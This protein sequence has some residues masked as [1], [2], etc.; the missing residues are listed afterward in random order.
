MVKEL[1]AAR[2]ASASDG[3]AVDDG[4][5]SRHE[6]VART[7]WVAA[8]LVTGAVVLEA[9]TSTVS[10]SVTVPPPT[11]G[12]ETFTTSTP[13]RTAPHSSS[14]P[15]PAGSSSKPHPPSVTATTSRPA[16][17]KA[18]AVTVLAAMTE[19]ERV[20]QL[21]MVDCPSTQASAVTLA[22]IRYQHVGSVI[23]DG[24]SE[25]SVVA[26]RSVTARLQGANT[27]PVGLF[28]ATDQEGGLVQRLQGPGFS[29]IPAALRQ[30]SITPA[31]LER[32]AGKWGRQLGQAGVNVNLGPVLDT[33]PPGQ[34]SNPPIGDLDR[35]FGSTPTVVAQHGVAVVR[36]LQAAGVSATV[37]HFPGLGRVAENT[38]T[39]SGVRD[40]V[41]TEHDAFLA[42]FA[43]AVKAAARFVMMSTAIYTRIDPKHPAAF[44]PT[45]IE[46]MLR[47]EL[48]FRGVVIS[49]DIG[50]AAQVRYIS[51]SQRA[52]EFIDA[53]G[54]IALSVNP[55]V[56]PAMI[57]AL[58]VKA[59]TDPSFRAKVDAAALTVLTAKEKAG[60]LP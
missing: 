34:S 14:R 15:S 6:T 25:L 58:R 60:L 16:P 41:T 7:W 20:G 56:V 31:V 50:S 59:A 24:A 5:L 3:I 19:A 29:R 10:P 49:D 2:A 55:D 57:K 18:N 21:L 1:A 13:P 47:Q 26:T 23:L 35:Q 46:G 8:V 54:D 39:T 53:G 51:P 32:D 38:D 45:I 42:P 30:G 22:F 27:G 40:T 43:A 52:V 17:A 4:K 37:K 28:V 48:G 11:T 12:V 36:G 33:V 44:S 9:C